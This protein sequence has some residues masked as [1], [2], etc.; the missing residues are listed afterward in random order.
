LSD[1]EQTPHLRSEQIARGFGVSVGTMQAK[2]KVLR[3]ALDLM[4]LD[5]AWSLPSSLGKNPLVW[6]VETD[7]GLILDMR[8]LPRPVQEQAFRAGLI[9]FIPA[10]DPNAAGMADPE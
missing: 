2:S 5:P 10:D 9:P 7:E 8:Y 1:P 4:P 6:M 3:E